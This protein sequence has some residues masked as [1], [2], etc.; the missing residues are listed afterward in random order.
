VDALAALAAADAAVA[1][2]VWDGTD[3]GFVALLLGGV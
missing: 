3:A 2:P 1:E